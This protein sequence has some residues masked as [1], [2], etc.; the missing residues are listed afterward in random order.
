MPE[1]PSI[2][3]AREEMQDFVG[4]SIVAVSGNAKIDMLRLLDNR[5]TEVL[6]W[7]KHLL[8]CFDGFML[9]VHFLMFGKYLIN[10]SREGAARL[11]LRFEGGGELNF[12]TAAIRVIEGS[13]GDEY[14]WRADI[15]NDQWDPAL[16]KRKMKRHSEFVIA[17]VLMDQEIFAGLG[18][19]IKNEVLFRA[20]IHPASITGR[21][22]SRKITELLRHIHEYA[23]E[24][25]LYKKAYL[26][27]AHWEIYTKRT[28][29]RDGTTV[30]KSYV[31]ARARRSFYCE[32]C[33]VLYS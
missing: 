21:I 27:K 12:Y 26:L 22:P 30:T 10:E 13:P 20:R 7:G 23:F 16:A 33:Q 29:P 1:G 5:I 31:G 2:V 11:S 28:C 17:D 18:N 8:I 3:I 9:R 32:T 6:S 15:M 25:L 19:I 24:F 4:R 14:D